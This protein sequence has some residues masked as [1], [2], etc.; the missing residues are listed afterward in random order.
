MDK[1]VYL[2]E[3]LTLNFDSNPASPDWLPTMQKMLLDL[4]VVMAP[5]AAVL[6]Y[7]IGMKHVL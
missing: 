4:M 1:I 7:S 6:S 3:Y 2:S 5:V